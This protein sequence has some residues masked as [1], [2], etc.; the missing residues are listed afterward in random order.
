[1]TTRATLNGKDNGTGAVLY[2]ALSRSWTTCQ[3][4]LP[5]PVCAKILSA[6]R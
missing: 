4:R 3:L 1:M 6:P 5:A 2:M